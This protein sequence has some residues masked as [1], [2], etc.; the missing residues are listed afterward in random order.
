MSARIRGFGSS[1]VKERSLKE[2]SF[3]LCGQGSMKNFHESFFVARSRR[4]FLH[5]NINCENYE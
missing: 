2:K 5:M 4:V 3:N 1:R